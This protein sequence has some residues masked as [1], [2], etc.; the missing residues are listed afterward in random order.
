SSMVFMVTIA[1]TLS[2]LTAPVLAVMNYKVVTGDRMPSYAVPPKWMVV[3]SWAGI[4][5]LTG[6]SS[7]FLYFRFVV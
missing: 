2:F 3:L 1:T 4:I 5:F 7:V 6:F